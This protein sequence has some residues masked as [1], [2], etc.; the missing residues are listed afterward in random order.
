M[1]HLI[2][3]LS[4]AVI[5]CGC[6]AS[7]SKQGEESIRSISFIDRNGMAET[8]SN[9]IRLKQYKDTDFQ[10][11]QSYQKI[12]RIYDRDKN[13]N[14]KAKMTSYYANG[15][16]KQYLEI[17]NSR[18]FGPY[19]EWHD[20]G[21]IKLQVCVIGGEPDLNKEAEESWLFDGHALVWDR[22]GQQIADFNYEKG[23]LTGYSNEF[24]ANGTV[25]RRTPYRDSLPHGTEETFLENGD[26][27]QFVNY[28]NG[29]RHGTS[30]RFWTPGELAVE[31]HF[32]QG[33]LEFGRYH[34][35]QGHLV[36]QINDGDGFRATFSRNHISELHEF[37]NGIP[38]GEVKVFGSDRKLFRQYQ[39]KNET[40][41]GVET[42]Y[43][44]QPHLRD[45]PKM[46]ITWFE[47]KIQGIAKTWYENGVQESNRE[48]SGNAKN[49]LATAWYQDGNLM[50]I[51][52]Y[53][54]DKLVRGEYFRRGDKYPV[55]QV[56]DGKGT[57]TLF[58]PE[59]NFLQK[60]NYQGG[61]PAPQAS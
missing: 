51:E 52:E 4:L 57:V 9:K 8:V 38:E 3:T 19:I 25:W 29:R 39:V 42:E 23:K 46:S 36:A 41:H 27:L 1:K 12:L 6:Q 54:F 30:K 24:H 10:Q 44:E 7:K 28:E 48:M 50:L 59:G 53:E 35:K 13:G 17:V 11:R 34:D 5:L 43:Y 15:Q 16:P 37:K 45:Q 56:R 21:K 26:L 18:A 20:N 22:E 2:T 58:D 55:S 33:K 49:G 40:K 31:E 61:I 47:G 32:V 60:I 14:I